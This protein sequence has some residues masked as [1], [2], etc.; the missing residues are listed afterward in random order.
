MR[1]FLP[2]IPG[3]AFSSQTPCHGPVHERLEPASGL[4]RTIAIIITYIV[5]I[6]P[7]PGRWMLSLRYCIHVHVRRTRP[8]PLTVLRSRLHIVS[9]TW[10][11][12]TCS[13][14]HSDP[15]DSS[16]CGGFPV[17]GLCW[18]RARE[19]AREAA[20]IAT[21]AC[22]GTSD[23]LTGAPCPVGFFRGC[24]TMPKAWSIRLSST[25]RSHGVCY[26]HATATSGCVRS[27]HG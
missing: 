20:R 23:R 2:V 26:H 14:Q 5:D 21:A 24:S 4:L 13:P 11:D 17:P 6:T 1:S 27:A 3:S 25:L 8:R 18:S 10:V 12:V 16:F 22:I 19:T 9:T 15:L 7:T